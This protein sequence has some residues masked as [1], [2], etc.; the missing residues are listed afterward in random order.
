MG[1]T[2]RSATNQP[3]AMT[4]PA[5]REDSGPME[6]VATRMRTL[7]LFLS[8]AAAAI[9]KSWPNAGAFGRCE[10]GCD[11]TVSRLVP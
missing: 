2:D 7:P 4:S 1:S 9:V 6:S 10:F 3:E 8:S 5:S 11:S